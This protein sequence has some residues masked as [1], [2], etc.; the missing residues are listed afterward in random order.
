VNSPIYF[1]AMDGH[2]CRG[3]DPETDFVILDPNDGNHDALADMDP[4]ADLPS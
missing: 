1:L 3:L 4:F 2:L